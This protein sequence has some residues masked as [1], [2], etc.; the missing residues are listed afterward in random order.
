MAEC[1]PERPNFVPYE[2]MTL[3]TKVWA[4]QRLDGV[5]QWVAMEKIHGAN[6]SFTV[7]CQSVASSSRD[8]DTS[9][10]KVGATAT[11][12]LLHA[13]PL[14]VYMA[15]RGDYLR[16]DENFYGVMSQ[17]EFLELQKEKA[18]CV[19]TSVI[20]RM[21]RAG[22]EEI[23]SITIVGELFGGLFYSMCMI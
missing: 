19:C 9:A 17:R 22:S 15:R 12:K 16:E 14:D 2:K 6:F 4:S 20:Q 10:D 5:K 1:A 11:S 8:S 7:A 13:R 18:R 3:S 21:D 23:T